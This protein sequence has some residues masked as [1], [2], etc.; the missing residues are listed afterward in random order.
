M[1]N[2]I[3]IIII[4][5]FYG[6]IKFVI[7]DFLEIMKNITAKTIYEISTNNKD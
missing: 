1:G 4:I 6:N 2:K 7:L 3:K 5:L